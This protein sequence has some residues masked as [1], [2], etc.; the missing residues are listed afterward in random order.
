M[1]DITSIMN[2]TT[3]LTNVN[4]DDSRL[5]GL[6]MNLL[7]Q[8][9][10]VIFSTLILF[11]LLGYLLFDPVKEALA[12]RTERIRG[13]ID[14]AKNLKNEAVELKSTYED[15][16]KD[17][18]N[19]SEEIL[20]ES[21]SKALDKEKEIVARAQEEAERILSRARL[22]IQR[23]KEQAK[24]DIRKEIIT[25][26]TI[27]ASKFVEDTIDSEKK[28]ALVAETINSMGEETWLN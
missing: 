7:I 17:V 15:K 16:L 26:A 24:D 20:A 5:F 27:M 19:E 21:R 14:S 2:V 18:D 25:V 9:G 4:A 13:D 8:A 22:E 10:F 23:E 1:A 6:D 11:I 28:D 12:K 3:L